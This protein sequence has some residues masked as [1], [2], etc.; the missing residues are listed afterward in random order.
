VRILRALAGEAVLV[1]YA[2][3]VIALWIAAERR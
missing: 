2:L 3:A 1:L